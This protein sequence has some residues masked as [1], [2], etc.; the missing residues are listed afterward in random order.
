MKL[1]FKKNLET[2]DSFCEKKCC[3]L[4]AQGN[5][6]NCKSKEGC[7]ITIKGITKTAERVQN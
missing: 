5:A 7:K 3:E 6:I 2:R 4:K 1:W